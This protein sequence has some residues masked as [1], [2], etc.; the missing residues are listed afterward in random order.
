MHTHISH[1]TLLID[2]LDWYTWPVKTG[3]ITVINNLRSTQHTY[4]GQWGNSHVHV[5]TYFKR[6]T[7]WGVPTS[8]HFSSYSSSITTTTTPSSSSSSSPF[9]SY[10][11]NF[12][13]PS[14]ISLPIVSKESQG[15]QGILQLVHVL[16]VCE[17]LKL[18]LVKRSNGG[19]MK[20]E[21]LTFRL[22][23]T[24]KQQH[25]TTC[26]WRRRVVL[27]ARGV[28]LLCTEVSTNLLILWFHTTRCVLI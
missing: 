24:Y 26:I 25:N 17:V 12:L 8:L 20:W 9:H 5:I 6:F 16:V 2:V 10:S 18:L 14:A 23:H 1:N 19:I 7:A 22:L 21:G 28:E 27:F 15:L 11:P 4:W 3:V 13:P